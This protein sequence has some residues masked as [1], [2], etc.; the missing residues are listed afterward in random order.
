MRTIGE[1]AFAI[2]DGTLPP[3]DRTAADTPTTPG[4]TSATAGTCRSSPIRSD[5]CSGPRRLRPAQLT[6][7]P[8]RNSTGSSKPSPKR[9]SD[10]GWTRRIRTPA[11]PSAY[12]FGARAPSGGSAATAPPT[13]RSAVSA[14]RSWPPSRGGASCGSPTAVPVG[15]GRRPPLS[16]RLAPTTSP[17]GA[18]VTEHC[19]VRPTSAPDMPSRHWM[20]QMG[21]GGAEVPPASQ[22]DLRT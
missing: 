1:K 13:Q 18:C 21:C 15:K 4:S 10:A 19:H 22:S 11:A 8:P 20:K 17:P 12:R 6:T 14:S 7:R 3:I 16:I 5:G 2:L 9:G